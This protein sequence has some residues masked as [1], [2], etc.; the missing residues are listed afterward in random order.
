M[1]SAAGGTARPV[2]ASDLE[3]ALTVTHLR[4]TYR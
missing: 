3:A 4:D 2:S 1:P